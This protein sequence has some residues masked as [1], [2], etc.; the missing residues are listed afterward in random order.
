MSPEGNILASV[1]VRRKKLSDHVFDRLLELIVSGSLAAGDNLPPE[2]ELMKQFGV[3][4]PAIRE[5]L[6]LLHNKGLIV[7]SHGE[8]SKIAKPDARTAL[9]QIDD[10][11]KLLLSQEPSSLANLKQLRRI[12]EIGV[13]EIAAE[14]SQ[15]TDIQD[16]KQLLVE[17]RK[18]L[19][20]AQ[21][22]IRCDINFHARIAQISANPLLK[23][24]SETM[25]KWLFDYHSSLLH[26]SG[27]EKTT[28]LE[29]E[30]IVM[31]LAENNVSG[32]SKLME[33]HLDRSE[34]LMEQK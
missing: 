12:F 21:A 32:A 7:I 17:Q 22:F 8:R 11:A 1:P 33:A 30:K 13:V 9:G 3:G 20:N 31:H 14:L 19:G 29:H 10:V 5:A 23:V 18:E 15:P 16:L 6:Q 27:N 28:L 26:W 4:R 34:P 25:L 24:V 2:R